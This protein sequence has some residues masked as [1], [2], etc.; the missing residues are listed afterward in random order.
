MVLSRVRKKRFAL[1]ARPLSCLW[2]SRALTR[3]GNE[4]FWG[5]AKN[6]LISAMNI[7]G[8]SSGSPLNVGRYSS[9][10]STTVGM[11][12][13]TDAVSVCMASLQEDGPARMLSAVTSAVTASCCTGAGLA[14]LSVMGSGCWTTTSSSTVVDGIMRERARVVTP[15]MGIGL[16]GG[17]RHLVEREPH[18]GRQFVTTGTVCV[19]TL[20]NLGSGDKCDVHLYRS[21][22]NKDRSRRRATWLPRSGCRRSDKGVHCRRCFGSEIKQKSG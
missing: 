7:S 19:Q 18:V 22:S 17:L 12:L 6:S 16:K 9:P 11:T 5:A 21:D 3:S 10:R 15:I 4:A 20:T 8:S 13:V 14:A 2:A 1:A